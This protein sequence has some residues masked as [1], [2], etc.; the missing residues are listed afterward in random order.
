MS[1][2]GPEFAMTKSEY[3]D[4]MNKYGHSPTQD[5]PYNH[6]A[7]P[8]LRLPADAY[9]NG[10]SSISDEDIARGEAIVQERRAE[11]AITKLPENG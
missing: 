3:D 4:Y 2:L 11:V 6:I 7:P 9:M 1:N 10:R 5:P 8:S